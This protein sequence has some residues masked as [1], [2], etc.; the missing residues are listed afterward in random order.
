MKMSSYDLFRQEIV[1]Q[2]QWTRLRTPIELLGN[3][4]EV[5]V[6]LQEIGN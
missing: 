5:D 3:A 4:S 1:L 2:M 6:P